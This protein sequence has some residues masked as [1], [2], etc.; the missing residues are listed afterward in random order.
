MQFLIGGSGEI[1]YSTYIY[2]IDNGQANYGF[3]YIN[4]TNTTASYGSSE[5]KVKITGKG[6]VSWTDDVF[7]VAKNNGAY[8]YVNLPNSDKIFSIED[9]MVMF[10]MD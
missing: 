7:L 3:K 4:T 2:K 1:T 9:F 8:Q 6:E 5:W 10:M